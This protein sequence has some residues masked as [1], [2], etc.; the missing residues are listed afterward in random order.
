[1][2]KED[3][4]I[5][6]LLIAVAIVVG[7]LFLIWRDEQTAY[8]KVFK[9]APK[10]IGIQ[11]SKRLP[12]SSEKLTRVYQHRIYHSIWSAKKGENYL[13]E[14]PDDLVMLSRTG[15]GGYSIEIFTNRFFD[16]IKREFKRINFIQ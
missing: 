2:K 11:S 16:D 12:I 1:M 5:W 8:V 10:D 14:H 7:S 6:F 9:M 3:R 13:A 4:L 15:D